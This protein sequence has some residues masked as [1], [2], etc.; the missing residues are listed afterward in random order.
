MT[1]KSFLVSV[2]MP[3]Y[4]REALI[5]DAIESVL[6]QSHAELELILVDDAS[7]DSTYEVM[8]QFQNL[9][10]RITVQRN[11]HNS[12]NGSIEWEPRNDGLRAARGEFIAYLDSDNTWEPDF[13]LELLNELLRHP[14][15]QLAHCDSRNFYSSKEQLQLVLSR[16]LRHLVF[17]DDESTIFSYSEL[18]PELL[19][20]SYYI[21]TNEIL[22]RAAVFQ[23]LGSLWTTIHPNR[24][25]INSSQAIVCPYRRHNDLHLVERIIASFGKESILHLSK[26]LT[27]FY[28]PGARPK[29]KN[30][31][32]LKKPFAKSLLSQDLNPGHFDRAYL[33]PAQ[34]P[35]VIDVSVGEY[36]GIIE[37]EVLEI[38]E[39]CVR[40][41]A[42]GETLFR[43]GGTSRIGDLY[44]DLAQKYNHWFGDSLFTPYSFCPTTG[45]HDAL[46]LAFS[47]SR[48][49]QPGRD[50]AIY[51]VPAYSF[52]S[53]VSASGLCGRPIVAQSFSEYLDQLYTES[54]HS[55]VGVIV[56]NTPHNPTGDHL[57][58]ELALGF[59]D[60]AAKIGCLLV[61]DITYQSFCSEKHESLR[62]LS[63]GNSVFCDSFAKSY[64]LPG[65]RF[66]CAFSR[67]EVLSAQLRSVKS[68]SSLLPSAFNQKLAWRVMNA[69]TD[70]N[71]RIVS[72]VHARK[73]LFY[74]HA[75]PF[76]G[77]DVLLTPNNPIP[78]EVLNV[79]AICEGRDETIDALAD[80]IEK[81]IGIKLSTSSAMLP[82]NLRQRKTP[83]FL[84]F[85]I[86]KLRREE[87]PI[88]SEK[89]F[90][91]L[92]QQ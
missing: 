84:R 22:H 76:L 39:Q 50:Q 28:Y 34:A 62:I 57:T 41:P 75:Q 31:M 92:S 33:Q 63:G 53:P 79:D 6:A 47:L 89:L 72:E 19:G 46:F 7:T 55:R 90:S 1:S 87:I 15:A 81:S 91:I 32:R 68:G 36:R 58:P 4:N 5:S 13:V 20:S 66:G 12:R 86:G 45:C 16:D 61:V 44:L 26:A 23:R 51:R 17:Q 43:Y 85:C 88:F 54:T 70:L 71:D 83:C 8:R 59:K 24:A 64:G 35:R 65:L 49:L 74:E 38:A 27:N 14:S 82:P 40:E 73:E 21:D 10:D 3:A 52:W 69:A 42:V 60:F 2:I 9:D 11:L 37:E 80:R 77:K 56:I 30:E 67:S 78:Y 25:E 18:Q 48:I 29:L